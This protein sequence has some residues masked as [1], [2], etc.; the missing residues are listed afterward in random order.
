MK[1][2][3]VA[4]VFNG[5]EFSNMVK[6][7]IASL[8]SKE[9]AQLMGVSVGSINNWAAGRFDSEHPHPSMTNFM[10][11][12]NLMDRSPSDFFTTGD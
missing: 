1:T 5:G 12:C 10:L 7:A 8:G 3:W 6:D 2:K 11:M 4:W 9:I